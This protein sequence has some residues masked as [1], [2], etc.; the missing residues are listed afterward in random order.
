MV[1]KKSGN[2]LLHTSLF[3]NLILVLAVSGFALQI[4]APQTAAKIKKQFF[5]WSGEIIPEAGA[6]NADPETAPGYFRR[7]WHQLVL[8]WEKAADYISNHS[9]LPPE[10]KA[11]RTSA[12]EVSRQAEKVLP[13]ALRRKRD[14][15]AASP[16]LIFVID[17][18]GHTREN[19]DL[20][21]ALGDNVTYA[22]LPL[23][24]HSRYFG[25]LSE[26][27]AAEVIL[28]QPL[29]SQNDIYPGPG[30]I[31]SRMN[32]ENA[33]LLFR[34]NL[35][36]VPHRAGL[37]NHMGSLGTKD[38]RLMKIILSEVK[39]QGLLFLDSK[40]TPQSAAG[41][42]AGGLGLKPLSRDVFLD[43]I[44][45][46]DA[47]RERVRELAAV[48]KRKGYAV[49]IGHYRYN[50]LKVLQEEIVRLRKQGYETLSLAELQRFL[51]RQG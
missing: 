38:T 42:I 10:K 29:E 4:Y 47:V 11:S 26:S 48:A 44:D 24:K 15:S 50:T 45:T 49:G 46:Q 41:S 51:A 18:M 13:A 17:D 32:D 39:A 20:L 5:S 7:K 16:K 31:T 22:V 25:R 8:Q 27:T 28:H 34:E 35:A 1:K 23:L 9:L 19:E 37:N 30:L 14:M 43:N 3:L 21:L 33:R 36:S 2:F 6:K 40:T 12:P